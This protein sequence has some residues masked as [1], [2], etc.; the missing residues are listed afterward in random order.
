MQGAIGVDVGGT[1]IKAGLVRRDGSIEH[2]SEY[3][4]A[5]A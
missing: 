2:R 4:T 3:P 1:Q 5:S